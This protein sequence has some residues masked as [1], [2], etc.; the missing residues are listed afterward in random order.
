MC[1]HLLLLCRSA[2]QQHVEQN[3]RQQVDCDLVV[4]FDDETTASEH[5]AGQLVSHLESKETSL[6]F[7]LGKQDKAGEKLQREMG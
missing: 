3:M 6:N 4:V 2:A 5:F 7:W 1:P